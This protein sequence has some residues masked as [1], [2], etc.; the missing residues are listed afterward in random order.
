ML[1]TTSR[2]RDRG[3]LQ[4]FHYRIP[5]NRLSQFAGL[6]E[7]EMHHVSSPALIRS[8]ITI[9][10]I[11]RCVEA[12]T[13]ALNHTIRTTGKSDRE[14]GRSAPWCN[15]DCAAAYQRHLPALQHHNARRPTEETREFFREVRRAKRAYWCHTID[16]I[17]D[18]KALFTIIG[19][20]RLEPTLQETP[21]VVDGKTLIDHGEKT[22]A[23]REAILCRFSSE[24]D[25]D[26]PPPRYGGHWS[27]AAMGHASLTGRDKEK[28]YRGSQHL[29]RDRSCDGTPTEVLLG[30]LK[31]HTLS[32]IPVLPHPVLFP[33]TLEAGRSGYDPKG[34]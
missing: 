31:T 24:Y 32:A 25:L 30:S 28:H 6:V 3:P 26:A 16:N 1:V 10:E 8:Y 4:Q 20:H 18:D 14:V 21:L 5:E 19:S 15:D 29:S 34:E 22:E 17:A 11:E 12:L 7:L 27:E 23:L 9:V 13:G 2:G 33:H